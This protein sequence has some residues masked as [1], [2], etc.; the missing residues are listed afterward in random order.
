MPNGLRPSLLGSIECAQKDLFWVLGKFCYWL[1]P[2]PKFRRYA[3]VG[4]TPTSSCLN[5]FWYNIS[6]ISLYMS[7]ESF[8]DPGLPTKWCPPAYLLWAFCLADVAVTTVCSIW[9]VANDHFSLQ[10]LDSI[11][12]S[13]LHPPPIASEHLHLPTEE[14]MEHILLT[15]EALL[16]D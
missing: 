14:S 6:F 3:G 16:Y 1:S 15:Q 7:H 4:L 13:V 10:I 9:T 2:S 8:V 11:T 5:T 12:P